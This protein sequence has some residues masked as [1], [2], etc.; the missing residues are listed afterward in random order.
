MYVH[1]YNKVTE[2]PAKMKEKDAINGETRYELL[3]ITEEQYNELVKGVVSGKKYFNNGIHVFEAPEPNR[4]PKWYEVVEYTIENNTPRATIVKKSLLDIKT[5]LGNI[6]RDRINNSI[7]SDRALNAFR[8]M[9]ESQLPNF[10]YI[11][12]DGV[13]EN[14][15]LE[16]AKI[17]LAEITAFRQ[18]QFIIENLYAS[19]YE[20]GYVIPDP[21]ITG[22]WDVNVI[23]G[24]TNKPVK[25][26]KGSK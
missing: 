4:A 2:L 1:F 18:T 8:E 10:V 9:V 7:H 14:Y 12:A 17:K 11:N 15:T 20:L 22:N 24:I 6:R 5:Y 16:K 25:T 19:A 21:G 3:A 13:G 26:K 23:N